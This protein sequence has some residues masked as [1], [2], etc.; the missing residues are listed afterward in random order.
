MRLRNRRV[1]SFRH[2]KPKNK[3]QRASRGNMYDKSIL[4]DPARI[5][6]SEPL[7]SELLARFRT[8]YR[9]RPT[10]S[11]SLRAGEIHSKFVDLQILRER[12]AGNEHPRAY[13]SH[14]KGVCANIGD[15][16]TLDLLD[17]LKLECWMYAWFVMMTVMLGFGVGDRLPSGLSALRYVQSIIASFLSSYAPRTHTR[18]AHASPPAIGGV[19]ELETLGIMHHALLASGGGAILVLLVDI[20]PNFPGRSHTLSGGMRD[21]Y[22]ILAG[23]SRSAQALLVLTA[24]GMITEMS[25]LHNGARV[26][27]GLAPMPGWAT[28]GGFARDA[29]AAYG[30]IL[31]LHMVHM[32]VSLTP[33]VVSC[34]DAQCYV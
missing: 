1:I 8:E 23:F 29:A 19:Y 4:D 14:G 34:I 24:I 9:P 27:A 11:G 6:A 2:A 31:V 7:A 5:A 15:P 13:S 3:A 18:G 10:L 28:M 30:A 16:A 25:D 32:E 12:A 33:V 22:A 21:V 20:L 17:K 26:D